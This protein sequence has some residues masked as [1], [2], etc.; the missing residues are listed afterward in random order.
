MRLTNTQSSER[1]N[2]K[3]SKSLI[4]FSQMK[5]ASAYLYLA[6]AAP[7][8]LERTTRKVPRTCHWFSPKENNKML[9]SRALKEGFD[10]L[11]HSSNSRPQDSSSFWLLSYAP[12]PNLLDS[13]HFF[14]LDFSRLCHR[15]VTSCFFEVK[16]LTVRGAS[17]QR[18]LSHL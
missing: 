16:K 5:V 7:R 3:A 15:R 17:K 12:L 8:A 6:P 14:F 13:C 18:P 4:G 11:Q 10:T 1:F 9:V 2:R